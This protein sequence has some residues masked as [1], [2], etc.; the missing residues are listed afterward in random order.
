PSQESLGWP[1]AEADQKR[2]MG[3]RPLAP[4]ASSV[5]T[6]RSVAFHTRRRFPERAESS[7]RH[8]GTE[9]ELMLNAPS[10]KR[11]AEALRESRRSASSG[12]SPFL[13]MGF[14]RALS[15]GCEASTMREPVLAVL[16]LVQ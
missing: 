1:V 13:R 16:K 14:R 4:V 6:V 7:A 3:L 8:A 5:A 15:S 9:V 12:S 11:W 2:G 10:S